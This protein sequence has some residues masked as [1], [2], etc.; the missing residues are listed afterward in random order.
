MFRFTIRELVLLTLV[1]AIGVA[2]FVQRSQLIHAESRARRSVYDL[3]KLTTY[4]SEC[5]Y[6]V[7]WEDETGTRGFV[8]TYPTLPHN[9]D[10]RDA[11]VPALGLPKDR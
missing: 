3:Q 11:V 2:W 9:S 5:G 1:V 10:N 7:M 6:R 4:L 8:C